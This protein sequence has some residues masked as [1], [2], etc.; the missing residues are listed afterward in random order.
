MKNRLSIALLLF[1]CFSGGAAE[2]SI[3]DYLPD[4]GFEKAHATNAQLNAK[5]TKELNG[6][7]ALPA[8]GNPWTSI[9]YVD[10][11]GKTLGD[12]RPA[13]E[14]AE[15]K[16]C[17]R[18]FTFKSCSWLSLKSPEFPVRKGEIYSVT[19]QITA[20]S[21]TPMARM[22]L[23]LERGGKSYAVQEYDLITLEDGWN[24]IVYRMKYDGPDGRARFVVN[25]LREKNATGGSLNLDD[26][27]RVTP[28]DI[29]YA[30][31]PMKPEKK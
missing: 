26:F 17:L 25:C 9:S 16:S 8:G 1:L 28:E 18:M 19:F 4:P 27:R 12:R 6:W 3:A 31:E 30:M 11:G 2:Q 5:G 15:G 22:R 10:R 7:S 20:D 24:T 21:T 13:L 23:F 29:E 14:P